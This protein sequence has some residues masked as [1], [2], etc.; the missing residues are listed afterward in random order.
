MMDL[1]IFSDSH[2]RAEAMQVVLDRQIRTPDA[3]IFLG[4]GLRD[5]QWL[6]TNGSTLFD[7][8]GNCDWFADA[9][10]PSELTVSF[11]EHRIFATHGHLYGV[12]S[13]LGGLIAR[14]AE[15]EADI[16][17]FGH[18]HMPLYQT[19]SQGSTVRGQTLSRPMHLFNAGI[20]DREGMR[21][22]FEADESEM[23]LCGIRAFGYNSDTVYHMIIKQRV[24]GKE[25][26]FR[27]EDAADHP[28]EYAIMVQGYS[29]KCP[30]KFI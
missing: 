18:T 5:I 8:R 25:Y 11:E 22:L 14:A 28:S 23:E 2:G 10:F 19:L 27:W 3:V 30:E 26:T 29:T 16:V 24:N 7:V 4:D 13:G 20:G 21:P 1:L 12:K 15:L 6:D 9:S 17:L